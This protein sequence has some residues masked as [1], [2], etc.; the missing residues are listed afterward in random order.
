MLQILLPIRHRRPAGRWQCATVRLSDGSVFGWQWI[1]M[2]RKVRTV[3]CYPNV[4]LIVRSKVPTK[5]QCASERIP[6]GGSLSAEQL[7]FLS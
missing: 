6:H 4:T 2:I 3:S 5:C 7:E 1:R